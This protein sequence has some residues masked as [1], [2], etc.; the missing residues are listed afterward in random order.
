[1]PTLLA[2][3]HRAAGEAAARRARFILA[4]L[5]ARRDEVYYQLFRV[6]EGSVLAEAEPRDATLAAVLQV[7]ATPG[8]MVTGEGRT[9]VLEGMTPNGH[10][11]VAAD[12]YARCGAG[13]VACIGEVRLL[14]GEAHDPIAL[15]PRYIKDFFLTSPH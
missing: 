1:M 7:L 12:A 5:D 2:L 11:L 8:V 13:A 6:E 9:K 4:V 15:E 3:A 14:Q 10:V